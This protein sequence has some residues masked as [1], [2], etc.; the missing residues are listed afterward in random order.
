MRSRAGGERL[1]LAA[2]RPRRALKS[3]LRD[4]GIPAWER[5]GL[6]LIFCGDALAAVAGVG[7]DTAFRAQP[8]QPGVTIAWNPKVR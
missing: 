6:P 5:A 4:A 1:Q 7:V 3:I 8:G 2:D